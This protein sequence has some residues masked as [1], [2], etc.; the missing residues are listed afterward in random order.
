[1]LVLPYVFA[2]S[3]LFAVE[4]N[5]AFGTLNSETTTDRKVLSPMGQT[6]TDYAQRYQEYKDLNTQ[7]AGAFGTQR[8]TLQAQALARAK[9]VLLSKLGAAEAHI[10]KILD[11]ISGTEKEA[12]A[13]ELTALQNYINTTK[14][15]IEAA[16]T[17]AELRTISVE[18]N[19]M[20][21]GKFGVG[22]YYALKIWIQRGLGIINELMGQGDLIQQHIDAAAEL[23][24]DVTDIQVMFDEA[25]LS[26]EGSKDAYNAAL[27]ELSGLTVTDPG[28]LVEFQKIR[29]TNATVAQAQADLKQAVK[30]LRTLYGQSPWEI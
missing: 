9:D 10:Q 7:A 28:V 11:R 6:V 16:T 3:T 15:K 12:L 21:A 14:A 30:D 8:T 4:Y 23:G 13:S 26:L 20:I 5:S 19:Q 2:F 29:E 27:S 24:G 18:M 1:M 22:N 25:M 17:L